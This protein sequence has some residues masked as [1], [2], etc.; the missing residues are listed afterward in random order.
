MEV[1]PSLWREAVVLP[2][3]KKGSSALV[4]DYRPGSLLNNFSKVFEIIIHDQLSYYFKSKL[5]PSQHGFIKF[6]PTVTSLITYLNKV[7]H[8]VCSQGQMDVIYFD[9]SQ[10]SD[11]VLHTL[12]I[13]KVKIKAVPLHAMEA[14]GGRDLGTRWG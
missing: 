2:I 5:H 6:K 12:L 14:L 11:K 3:F 7:T 13:V 10:A 1:F 9:L 4:T 8:V